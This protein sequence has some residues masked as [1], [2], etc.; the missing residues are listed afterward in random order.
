MVLRC[1]S[2][3]KGGDEYACSERGRW[4]DEIVALRSNAPTYTPQL[5][6]V[7]REDKRLNSSLMTPSR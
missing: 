6:P 5:D 2:G 7:D 1:K 3:V 4:V